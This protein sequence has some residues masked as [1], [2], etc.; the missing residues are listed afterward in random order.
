MLGKALLTISIVV[1]LSTNDNYATLVVAVPVRDGLVVCADKRIFNGTTRTFEDSFV[2]VREVDP[3]TVFAATNTIGFLN[4]NS[5]RMEF[6]AFDIVSNYN[7]RH[8][9][10]DD[11]A[12]WDGLRGEIRKQ[13]LAYLAKQKFADQ[14]ETDFANSRLLFNVIL[15]SV[16]GGRIRSYSLRVFYEKARIPI[17]DIPQVLIEDV[18]TPQLMGN[19][20]NVIA[21]ISAHPEIARSPE[22]SRFDQAVFNVRTITAADAVTFSAALFSLTSRELPAAEVSSSYDCAHLRYENAIEWIGQTGQAVR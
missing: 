17:I 2:K 14:P 19:G 12:F 9:F 7:A 4:K 6:D 20:R 18:R 22:I 16:A 8:K 1:I 11:R 10:T 3:N 15:Y 21:Y 13:L 5:G